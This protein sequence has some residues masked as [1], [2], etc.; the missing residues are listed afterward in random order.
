VIS[1]LTQS[2]I[3]FIHL[4]SNIFPLPVFAFF[5]G[6]LEEVIAPIPSPLVMALIGSIA[7]TEGHTLIYL[8]FLILIGSIGKTIGSLVVYFVADKGENLITGKFKRTFG[9][10][11]RE[12]EAIGKRLN[13]GWK[14][15]LLLFVLRAIPIMPSAPVSVVCGLLKINLRTYTL[16]TFFGVLVRGLFYS[17]LG[18]IGVGALESIIAGVGNLE[19]IGYAILLTGIVIG[20][21]LIY[22]SRRKGLGIDFL[23]KTK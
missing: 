7:E 5:G 17:Y 2:I 12:I 21:F 14:D 1:K 18:Y 22:R 4:A 20:L 3:S 6:A 11:H 8:G 23:D 19:T 15:A 16:S 10:S 13:K 9:A